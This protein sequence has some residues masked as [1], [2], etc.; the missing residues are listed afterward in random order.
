MVSTPH[1]VY[2]DDDGKAKV[3]PAEKVKEV[4]IKANPEQKRG[5]IAY[6]MYQDIGAGVTQRV[7]FQPYFNIAG[8]S[9]VLVGINS[10]NQAYSPAKIGDEGGGSDAKMSYFSASKIGSSKNTN[11]LSA[12]DE[13]YMKT[14]YKAE[15]G[16][17]YEEKSGDKLLAYR[18][19]KVSSHNLE[20]GNPWKP[21]DFSNDIDA[22]QTAQKG[23]MFVFVPV[24][25]IKTK[26]ATAGVFFEGEEAKSS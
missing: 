1:V 5:A 8:G 4:E 17:W 13:A 9:P 15:D 12:Q 18:P 21:E 14:F 20:T 10:A 24:A 19:V 3:Q 23:T 7:K 11:A 6:A 16:Y 2:A 25:D 26:N 22:F